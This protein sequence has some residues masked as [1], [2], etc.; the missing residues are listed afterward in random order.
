MTRAVKK[1][2]TLP[3]KITS[4]LKKGVRMT[5]PFSVEIGTEVKLE[6]IATLFLWKSALK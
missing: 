4:L 5:N 6:R 2:A 3:P 1:T